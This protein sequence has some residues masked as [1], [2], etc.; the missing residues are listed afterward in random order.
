MYI[1]KNLILYKM[2]D[3][4]I[5]IIIIIKLIFYIYM[6][7]RMQRYIKSTI[8]IDFKF[9]KFRLFDLKKIYMK[10]VITLYNL[11]EVFDEVRRSNVEGR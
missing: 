9:V 8:P 1:V 4:T 3:I 5:K 7:Y 11:H 6:L 10:V 2:C